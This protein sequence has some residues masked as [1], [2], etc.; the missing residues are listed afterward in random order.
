MD[1]TKVSVRDDMDILLNEFLTNTRKCI[2]NDG[3]ESELNDDPKII[4]TLI[5]K[6]EKI[7]FWDWCIEYKV[8]SEDD[9]KIE[10]IIKKLD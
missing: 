5:E 3:Y 8:I 2:G 9:D 10:F 4:E 1:K 6:T 7:K